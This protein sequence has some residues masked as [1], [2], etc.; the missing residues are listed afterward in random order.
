[1]LR[2]VLRAFAYTH[3]DRIAH[4]DIEPSNI[5]VVSAGANRITR[6][7]ARAPAPGRRIAPPPDHTVTTLKK[8]RDYL[9]YL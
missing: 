3:R 4:R 9:T 8:H 6:D 1:M 2:P 7:P 5:M